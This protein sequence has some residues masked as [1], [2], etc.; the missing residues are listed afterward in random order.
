MPTLFARPTGAGNATRSARSPRRSPERPRQRCR[1]RSCHHLCFCPA[2]LA[3]T[4][5]VR[6][7]PSPYAVSPVNRRPQR[8][9]SI[10]APLKDEA[11]VLGNAGSAPRH[12]HRRAARERT[13]IPP[14]PSKPRAR[15]DR[16]TLRRNSGRIMYEHY[17]TFSFP[18][19][20]RVAS[21]PKSPALAIATLFDP[22]ATL[23]TSLKLRRTRRAGTET[24]CSPGDARGVG[25][26][27]EAKRGQSCPAFQAGSRCLS[28]RITRLMRKGRLAE[29]GRCLQVFPPRAGRQSP[30]GLR[31]GKMTDGKGS[32]KQP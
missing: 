27:G 11:T 22:P 29:S 16:R 31:N 25:L 24:F 2:A 26:I 5:P 4:C 32:E 19:H 20:T 21:R 28:A 17:A 10:V 7:S 23:P 1:Q 13:G 30:S 18:A 12:G 15:R 3:A 8:Y 14:Q 9:A 6:L